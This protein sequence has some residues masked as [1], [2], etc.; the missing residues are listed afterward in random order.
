M[1]DG[2]RTT[3]QDIE[4]LEKAIIKRIDAIFD[5]EVPENRFVRSSS[6]GEQKS[7]AIAVTGA[8]VGQLESF[9]DSISDQGRELKVIMERLPSAGD[10]DQI[11]RKALVREVDG[12]VDAIQQVGR[13]AGTVLEQVVGLTR[14]MLENIT[15]R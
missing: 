4:R 5:H 14:Q 10:Q 2:I 9:L 13:S 6:E 11:K 12:L 15:P 1:Q 8:F 3:E 7:S